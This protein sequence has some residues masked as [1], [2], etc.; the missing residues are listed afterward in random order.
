MTIN[1][2]TKLKAVYH[3]ALNGSLRRVASAYS[4]GKSTL[5]RWIQQCGLDQNIPGPARNRFKKVTDQILLTI[6]DALRRNPFLTSLN[7]R[8]LVRRCHGVTL[9]QETVRRSIRRCGITRKRAKPTIMKSKRYWEQLQ[10]KREEFVETYRAI[11]PNEVLSIDETAIH[12][13][14]H[15]IYGYSTRGKRLRVPTTTMRA[16]KYSLIMAMSSTRV[17]HIRYVKGS[18]NTGR[19]REFIDQTL[20]IMDNRG[21]FTFLMDN[22]SFHK[23]ASIRARIVQ[24]GHSVRRGVQ[25]RGIGT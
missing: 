22:V 3:Y 6:Q 13:N 11:Q 1:A 7:L 5:Q 18:Y 10:V 16:E 9:S 24:R 14:L 17:E 19:F 8:S 20:D 12:A 21:R 15:P 25:V 23:N 2:D 4:V